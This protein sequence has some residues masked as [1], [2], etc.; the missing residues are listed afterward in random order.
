VTVASFRKPEEAV[1]ETK[2][3]TWED[4]QPEERV[5][6]VLN[7]VRDHLDRYEQ[8][9]PDGAWI[10]ETVLELVRT[11]LVSLRA[12]VENPDER[13]ITWSAPVVELQYPVGWTW[14]EREPGKAWGRPLSGVVDAA[15]LPDQDAAAEKAAEVAQ[16]HRYLF[17]LEALTSGVVEWREKAPGGTPRGRPPTSCPRTS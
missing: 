14:D 5:K 16:A 11:G 9:R 6:L 2:G 17:V 15:E 4:L 10:S 3:R 12:Y 7:V 8:D 1:D 13:E